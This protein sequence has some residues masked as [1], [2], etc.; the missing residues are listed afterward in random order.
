MIFESSLSSGQVPDDWKNARVVP[1]PKKG[2]R[3]VAGNYRP[4]S[5]TS[6]VCKLLERI[7]RSKLMDHLITNKII[8]LSQHGFMSERSCQTNLLEFLDKIT[9]MLDEGKA[10]DIIYLDYSKA[11]DKI[12]HSKLI[13]KLEAHGIRG[14]VQRWISEWLRDRQQWVEI[15]GCKSSRKPVTSGVPQGSVLGPLL[16]I[17][18]I[19]DIDIEANNID[20]L[21][22]FAD[23]TK[24]AKEIDGPEDAAHLQNCINNLEEWGKKWS[25]EFNVKKCKIMHCGRNNPKHSY[26]IGGETLKV[27][28]SEKDIGVTITSNLKPSQHCQEAA[29]RARCELGKISKC[30]HFRDKKVF[31]RLYMQFVRPHLEFSSSVWSP[32]NQTDIDLLENVQKKAVRMVSGLRASTYEDRLKEIGL[33]TLEKRRLMFDMIQ[34]YKLLNNVGNIELSVLKIGDNSSERINTRSQSDSLNLVKKR[35]SLD[36]RKHFF[37]ERVVEHWNRLPSE[38]KHAPTLRIFKNAIKKS[39]D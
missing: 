23:D 25:M 37:T 19:N 18:Y 30:F 28:D 26:S 36:I 6:T 4:V 13:K 24:G 20:I 32:W 34:V 35:S 38:V 31:L 12:C 14:N 17:I 7:M 3:A 15:K 11:F 39:L 1:L 5:L 2:S 8:N 27:V 22:K 10:A 16:F 21:R 9:A 29:G 33:W